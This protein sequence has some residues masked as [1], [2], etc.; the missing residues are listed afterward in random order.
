M[1]VALY[2]VS[3]KCK[4]VLNLLL[5]QYSL[6]NIAHQAYIHHF[7]LFSFSIFF[8]YRIVDC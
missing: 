3:D 5:F 8:V 1:Q 2:K 6:L 7:L 4:N